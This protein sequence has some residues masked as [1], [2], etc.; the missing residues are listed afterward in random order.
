MRPIGMGDLALYYSNVQ[1][2]TDIKT[3]LA[4]LAGEV[5]S[6]RKADLSTAVA[7]DFAPVAG[8]ENS[9]YRL[10]AF[11]T[12]TAEATMF[13]EAQQT[14]LAAISDKAV[15]LASAMLTAGNS[16]SDTLI[17]VTSN[18]ADHK[19]R[20]VVGHL[21]TQI[22]DRYV[23]SGD[24]TDTRALADPD[25]ILADLQV[26]VAGLTTA[27]AVEQAVNDWFDLPGGGFETTAYTGS[28]TQMQPYRVSEND[29]VRMTSTANE[30]DLRDVL[31][32]FALAAL[33]HGG[34]LAGDIDER[35][36]LTTRAG[37]LLFSSDKSAADV[38]AHIGNV[39]ARL[40]DIAVQ[41]KV[42]ISM[43]EM[44][45]ADLVSVDPFKAATEYH[46]VQGQLESLYTVTARMAQL[47]LSDYL[48]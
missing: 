46:A 19:F 33:V 25:T 14:A 18:D 43:L 37:E 27:T 29:A 26:A 23:F 13:A 38:R 40:S 1:R 16:R 22:A 10:S 15:E 28:T 21:N 48:R 2:T 36:A 20:A 24:A 17:D 5:S 12:A 11:E 8:I 45:R 39:E 4:R 41:N 6:G 34:V 9:L 3:Q 7:G 31:K 32:G 47:R 42:E 44:A 35:V 30:Q